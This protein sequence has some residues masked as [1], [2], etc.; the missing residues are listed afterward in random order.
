M[1]L[2]RRHRLPKAVDHD[3]AVARRGHLPTSVQQRVRLVLR[4]DEVA[5]VVVALD[6]ALSPNQAKQGSIKLQNKF[7]T[8][9]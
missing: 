3:Q 4:V 1:E 8:K 2:E 7:Q 6:E 5:V 9:L